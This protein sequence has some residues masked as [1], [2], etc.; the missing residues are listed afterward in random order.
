MI[1]PITYVNKMLFYGGGENG[2]DMELWNVIEQ[3]R[4]Y[5]FSVTSRIMTVVQSPVVD[6]VAVGCLDG[7]IHLMNLLYDEVLFTFSHKDGAIA[8]IAFLTD[9]TLGQSIMATTSQD[10]DG[11]LVFWDLNAHKILAEM[12]V[13]HSGRDISHLEFIANEP[14]LISASEDD[15]SIKMWLFEKG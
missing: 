15:N 10:V 12:S 4:I 13:P 2:N 6:I 8:S 14:V 1:H 3:E 5:K 7:S 11:S 9:A